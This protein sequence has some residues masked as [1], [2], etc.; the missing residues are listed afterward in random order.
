MLAVIQQRTA[1]MIAAEV[2]AGAV[3]AAAVAVKAA[4]AVVVVAEAEVTLQVCFGRYGRCAMP[5]ICFARLPFWLVFPLL[6][7]II[8][9]RPSFAEVLSFSKIGTLSFSLTSFSRY[10]FVSFSF[11]LFSLI[12]L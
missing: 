12:S 3:V 1:T 7:L 5:I 10:L 11:F 4:A 8:H 9:F 6:L 2:A